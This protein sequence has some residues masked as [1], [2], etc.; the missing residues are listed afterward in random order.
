MFCAPVFCLI[1][2]SLSLSS[3]V[4]PNRCLKNFICAA[5]KRCSSLFFSTQTTLP[6][7]NAALAV[8][9][10]KKCISLFFFIFFLF[11]NSRQF[12][13]LSLYFFLL[14]IEPS[15]EFTFITLEKIEFIINYS[16]NASSLV[17]HF[18]ESWSK[19]VSWE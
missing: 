4:I 9:K 15:I 5:S 7:L 6:N 3:F 1:H 17:L 10:K 8:I 11:H 13:S 16:R 2:W 19:F 12:P 18:T 14:I